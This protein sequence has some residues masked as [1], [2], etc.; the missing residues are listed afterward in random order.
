MRPHQLHA[1]LKHAMLAPADAVAGG[2]CADP[3]GTKS[4]KDLTT[5]DWKTQPGVRAVI[6]D[7]KDRVLLL[8]R[9]THEAFHPNTW[10]LPGGAK[11]TDESFLQGAHRELK[12]ETGLT[13]TR[14][15]KVHHF[16]FPGGRGQAYLMRGHQGTLKTPK[17]EVSEAKWF[18]T[19]KLPKKLFPQTKS[20]VVGLLPKT[21][22]EMY[23]LYKQSG[24]V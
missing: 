8:K 24:Q 20:I 18:D 9:P 11:E 6:L 10:N 4:A 14:E 16:T 22:H 5:D 7:A 1:L 15:G 23:A 13:A 17:R 3:S 21:A 2:G 12:E 19:D